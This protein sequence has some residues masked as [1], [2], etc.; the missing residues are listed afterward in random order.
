ME[1][2]VS[3][4][5]MLAKEQYIKRHDRVCSQL[6]FDIC[7]E[8]G[9]KWTVNTG[10]NIY[11]NHSKQAMQAKLPYYGTNKCELTELFLTIN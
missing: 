9:V 10:M 5:P 11:Q 8:I 6:H 1:H 4:C 2:I 3:A 7:K